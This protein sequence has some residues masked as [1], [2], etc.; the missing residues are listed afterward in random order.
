VNAPITRTKQ[1][2]SPLRV[3]FAGGGTG[4]HLC[5]AVAVAQELLA[6]SPNSEVL[7]LGSDRP[8]ER[9]IIEPTGFRHIALRS[10]APSAGRI[11]CLWEN[12][13][14]VTAA[15]RALRAFQP[16]VVLGLGGFP[17]VP[18]V[19]AARLV[20]AP[21]ALFEPNAVAGRANLALARFAKEVYF[22]WEQTVVPGCVPRQTGTPLRGCLRAV[23]RGE[24]RRALGL[25]A[26]GQV[27]LIMGGSQGAQAFNRWVI[28]SLPRVAGH[29]IDGVSFVHLA[30]SPEAARAV[31]AGYQ[32]AGITAHV[33]PFLHD[34]ALAYRAAD[35]AVVRAGGGTLAEMLAVGLPGVA[36]PLPRSAGDHQRRNALAFEASGAGECVEQVSL[37][38]RILAR[39]L[40]L[41]RDREQLAIRAAEAR[42]AGRPRAA[43]AVVEN[44]AR[45]AGREPLP[46]TT[47][48]ERENYITA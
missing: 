44:L 22:H 3:A 38:S 35:L 14:G 18:G 11:R 42:N 24:A 33:T 12:G 29:R 9:A 32:A 8:V 31:E 39:V 4:G 27:I 16:D 1:Q 45:L 20:G 26:E 41:A 47:H 25:P 19:L 34:M 30:G 46:G 21:I 17:S 36:V 5:P 13:W 43:R 10:A 48:L 7:F 6:C 15:W 28:D 40:N 2:L 23:D 37:D